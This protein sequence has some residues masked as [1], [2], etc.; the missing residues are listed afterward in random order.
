M[1]LDYW[2]LVIG[3]E[4][5]PPL[6]WRERVGVRAEDRMVTP[7]RTLPRRGGGDLVVFSWFAP[8]RRQGW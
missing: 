7:T 2:D 4:N 6:P 5:K 1:S 3:A 8:A